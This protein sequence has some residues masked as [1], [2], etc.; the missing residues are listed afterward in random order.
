MRHVL[1]ALC[2]V[3]PVAASA[4]EVVWPTD[5]YCGEA[6]ARDV[7]PHTCR[8]G[9]GITVCG[10]EA[11]LAGELAHRLLTIGPALSSEIHDQLGLSVRPTTFVLYD[12]EEFDR[13]W[14]RGHSQRREAVGFHSSGVVHLWDR[15]PVEVVGFTV[16][17][18]LVHAALHGR[19][20]LPWYLEQG[21]AYHLEG[22]APSAEGVTWM[23]RPTRHPPERA[24]EDLAL[25]MIREAVHLDTRF[26]H[27]LVRCGQ[28]PSCDPM[29]FLDLDA[30]VDRFVRLYGGR[31]AF[32]RIDTSTCR[33]TT[34]KSPWKLGSSGD[35]VTLLRCRIDGELQPPVARR[36]R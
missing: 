14:H 18:E 2:L 17:H 19:S 27:S 34:W 22:A 7:L 30:A 3:L 15:V 21:L 32:Q 25:L 36:E 33:G 1:T 28:T 35:G 11:R 20:C 24:L 9:G 16:R 12:R 8:N 5:T 13:A 6:R 4:G 26:V 23:Q 29:A 10:D 31:D